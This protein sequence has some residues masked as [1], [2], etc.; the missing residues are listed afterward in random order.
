MPQGRDCC[1]GTRT[2]HATRAWWGRGGSSGLCAEDD[3]PLWQSWVGLARRRS[4]QHFAGA[5]N[6]IELTTVL[7]SS[8]AAAELSAASS[9]FER[10]LQGHIGAYWHTRICGPIDNDRCICGCAM[11]TGQHGSAA[12]K[13]QSSHRVSSSA[14]QRAGNWLDDTNSLA[15]YSPTR[16]TVSWC[17]TGGGGTGCPGL[18]T[19]L[20]CVQ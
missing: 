13:E 8:S 4:P 17:C 14:E 15:V 1:H 7:R 12:N 5:S 6:R 19:W 3:S 10:T 9:L 2:V 16:A 18:A 11:Q 20:R